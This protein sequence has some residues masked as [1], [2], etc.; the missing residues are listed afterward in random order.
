MRFLNQKYSLKRFTDKLYLGFIGTFPVR[1]VT[2][3]NIGD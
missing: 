2:L 3:L 1:K